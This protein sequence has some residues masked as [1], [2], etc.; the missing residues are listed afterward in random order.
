MGHVE[1][2]KYINDMMCPYAD[3]S[4]LP[5]LPGD[6]DSRSLRVR[7]ASCG[8]RPLAGRHVRLLSNIRHSDSRKKIVTG[9]CFRRGERRCQDEGSAGRNR[10]IPGVDLGAVLD[11]GDGGCHDYPNG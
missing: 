6:N 10:L 1:A 8:F 11:A 3:T 2:T 9:G 7:A 4:Y 5:V